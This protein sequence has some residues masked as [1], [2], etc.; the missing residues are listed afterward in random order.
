MDIHKK[1]VRPEPA[2]GY[3]TRPLIVRFEFFTKQHDHQC[4]TDDI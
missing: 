4:F 3:V 2:E 1:A